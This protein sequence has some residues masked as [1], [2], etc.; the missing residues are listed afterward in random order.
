MKRITRMILCLLISL[1]LVEAPIMN[2][3]Q[4]GMISTN[5]LVENM[6]RTQTQKRVVDFIQRDD[7][8]SQMMNLGVSSAEAAERVAQLSD[9]ELRQI[10]GEIDNSM[11]GG[12]VGGI[13]VV[14]LVVLLILYLAKRI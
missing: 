9:R 8:K 4:A 12:D 10:A 11:A 14:V 5:T 7:V 6:T 13:L 3:A 2:T 1:T